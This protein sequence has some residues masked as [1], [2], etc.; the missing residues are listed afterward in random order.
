[1]VCHPVQ[2]LNYYWVKL[3]ESNIS[4]DTP[5]SF[6]NKSLFLLSFISNYANMLFVVFCNESSGPLH[7]SQSAS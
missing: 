2:M 1:V 5:S 4:N 6:D 7:V 3:L